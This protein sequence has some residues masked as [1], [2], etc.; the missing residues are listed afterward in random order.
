M[1]FSPF[2]CPLLAALALGAC[3]PTGESSHLTRSQWSF[4]LIDGQRPISDAADIRFARGE[5]SVLVGCNRITGPWRISEDRLI[6]G[7][8]VQTEMACPAP[9]WDQEKAVGSLLAATPRII[10]Q[11]DRM[12]LQSSGHTAEL[13]R[14]PD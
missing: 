13:I 2:A 1:P 9:A 8:L 14:V 12:T 11:D 10:L 6:A 3:A 7:P 4:E 5:I